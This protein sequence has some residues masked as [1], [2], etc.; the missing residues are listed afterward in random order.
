MH[1]EK[2]RPASPLNDLILCPEAKSEFCVHLVDSYLNQAREYA[3]ACDIS[4][5]LNSFEM[6]D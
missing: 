5:F 6:E 4:K 2:K 1:K 3:Q